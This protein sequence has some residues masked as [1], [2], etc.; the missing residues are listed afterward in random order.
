[1][2]INDHLCCDITV[3]RPLET[4]QLSVSK[5]RPLQAHTPKKVAQHAHHWTLNLVV[6]LRFTT[7]QDFS[8]PVQTTYLET[9]FIAKGYFYAIPI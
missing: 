3:R 5:I 4:E 9:K 6:T 7:L 1:M 2:S 8:T